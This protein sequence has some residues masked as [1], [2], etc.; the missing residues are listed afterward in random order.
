MIWCYIRVVSS[1][2]ELERPPESANAER[3][4]CEMEDIG[5]GLHGIAAVLRN[6][7]LPFAFSSSAEVLAL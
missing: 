5:L 3:R 4:I 7:A 6:L 1:V 2:E